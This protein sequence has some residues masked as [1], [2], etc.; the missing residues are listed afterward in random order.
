MG[1]GGGGV[2]ERE[3]RMMSARGNP[4]VV[5]SQ[6]SAARQPNEMSVLAHAISLVG[7]VT[8]LLLLLQGAQGTMQTQNT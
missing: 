7:W 2:L 4:D 6:I 3:G 5:L 8:L 1:R